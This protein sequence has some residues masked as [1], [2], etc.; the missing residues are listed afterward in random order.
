MSAEGKEIWNLEVDKSGVIWIIGEIDYTIASK[1]RKELFPRLEA[2]S[3]D[4]AFNLSRLTYLDSSGLAL[5]IEINRKLHEK[6]RKMIISEITP[7]VKKVF[8]LTQVARLF[9]V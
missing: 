4:V 9:G 1:L 8:D 6:G 2:T 5:L 7:D 3:D